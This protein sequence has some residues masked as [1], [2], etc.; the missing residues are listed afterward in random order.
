MTLISLYAGYMNSGASL[1]CRL[2]GLY[3]LYCLHGTQPFKPPFKIYL[4]LGKVTF[5]HT[6][7]SQVDFFF[8]N[9]IF[10]DACCSTV[11]LHP[12]FKKC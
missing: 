6:T 9:D 8:F 11:H 4:S 1:S 3:C 7:L 2:G 5:F 12:F 10:H